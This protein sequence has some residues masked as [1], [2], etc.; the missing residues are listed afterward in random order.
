MNKNQIS[1]AAKS[2]AGRAQE[3]FGKV[4]GNASRQAA[5]L[6]LQAQGRMQKACGDVKEALRSSR[7][8]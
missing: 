5:G 6:V 2:L 1:G 3:Q 4:T 7:H 8:S